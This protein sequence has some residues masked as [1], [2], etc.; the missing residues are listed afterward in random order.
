LEYKHGIY[1]LEN[2]SPS[3]DPDKAS[4]VQVVVGAA[5]VNLVDNAPLNEAVEVLN[6]EQGK[7]LFGFSEEFDNF[8]LSAALHLSFEEFGIAPLVLINV[9][10]KTK[11]KKS[12]AAVVLDVSG[13]IATSNITGILKE[14]VVV[15]NE[16]GSTTYTLTD[17]YTLDFNDVGKL[18]VT[19]TSTGL[20]KAET[21]VSLDYD[22]IDP[23]MIS[24]EDI[25][26]AYDAATNKYTGLEVVK[27]IYPKLSLV[28]G[29]LTIPGH[30]HKPGVARAAEKVTRDLHD[31]FNVTFI[32][33]VD[34]SIVDHTKV[35][36]WK[37]DNGYKESSTLLAWP[38]A[39]CNGSIYW[40]SLFLANVIQL[41][42]FKGGDVPYQ[43][44]SN[45]L[46]PLEAS[47]LGNGDEIYLEP[48]QANVLNA[49]GIV[50]AVNMSGWRVWGNET[51]AYP[52][53]TDP[54]DRFIMTRR[55]FDFIGNQFV[56]QFIN[57]VD[58]P[59]NKRLI[60]SIVDEFN[61]YLNN[62]QSNGMIMGGKISFDYT[63][64]TAENLAEGK[65][66]FKTLLGG[67]TPAKAIEHVREFD[68]SGLVAIGGA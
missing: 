4:T 37:D 33:D 7:S 44:P 12:S 16:A 56:L 13:M 30:S 19:L 47:V 22:Y 27:Q 15:K 23:S 8:P 50:T 3:F 48:G 20:A 25:I 17:D 6:I 60:E 55:I 42:D 53:T 59:T 52:G 46:M 35:G 68:P 1:G 21:K 38:K 41:L 45:K 65:L 18:E 36:P 11:H 57:E 32:A 2:P 61:M 39:K 31:C 62:L 10:D 34:P 43:S 64:A 14:S 9:L 51:C 54:K 28:P 26:G 24:D 63:T 67:Y 58:D 29:L 66:R 40:Y 49:A 5:P